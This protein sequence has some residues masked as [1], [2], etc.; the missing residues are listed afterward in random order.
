MSVMFYLL[1]HVCMIQPVDHRFIKLTFL[2]AFQ[3]IT[4]QDYMKNGTS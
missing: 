2:R 4:T 1:N 3:G